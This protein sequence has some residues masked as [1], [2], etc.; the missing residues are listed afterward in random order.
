MSDDSRKP[1][2]PGMQANLALA[3]ATSID[4]ATGA[5]V[6]VARLGGMERF[7][8]LHD[9]AVRAAKQTAIEGM[10]IEADAAAMDGMLA[11]VDFIFRAARD[12]VE[13]DIQGK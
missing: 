2:Q 11:M 6:E 12:E 1:D 9:R 3:L 13:T 10:S 7:D 5:L 4:I 8:A